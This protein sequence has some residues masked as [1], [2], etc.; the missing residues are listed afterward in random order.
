[1][2][3]IGQKI[4]LLRLLRKITQTELGSRAGISQANLSNIEKGRRDLTVSTLIRICF[5]LGV[6][7]ASL[8]E[9][10]PQRS[11]FSFSR[12]FVERIARAAWGDPLKL[13]NGEKNLVGL[14]RDLIPSLSQR[15]FSK[16]WI[17]QRWYELRSRFSDKEIR[18]LTDRIRDEKMRRG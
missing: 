8:F 5:A 12:R 7:P 4:Y 15:K 13:S 11:P 2:L 10:E 17:D 18:I 1:M 14:L 16:K 3:P 6:N 9:R